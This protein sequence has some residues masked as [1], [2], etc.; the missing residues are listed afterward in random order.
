[1]FVL[2]KYGQQKMH[3]K[4]NIAKKKIV[5][6]KKNVFF[7]KKKRIATVQTVAKSSKKFVTQ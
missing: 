6:N 2:E 7:L 4:K 5:G 1:M 3:F